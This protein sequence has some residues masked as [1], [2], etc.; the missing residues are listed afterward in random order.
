MSRPVLLGCG[1][2]GRMDVSD[3]TIL[4]LGMAGVRRLPFTVTHPC[5][6]HLPKE[7]R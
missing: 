4:R 7:N 3:Q 1:C 5:P 6:E 2:R